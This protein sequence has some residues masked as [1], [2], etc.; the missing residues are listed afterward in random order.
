MKA[1][2]VVEAEFEQTVALDD[3]L[4]DEAP[5]IPERER[6][7]SY[8]SGSRLP[9]HDFASSEEERFGNRLDSRKSPPR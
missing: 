4:P 7:P 1:G 6:I 3:G 9:S 5:P 2:T 8:V